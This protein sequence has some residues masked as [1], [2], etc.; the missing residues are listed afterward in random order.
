[1]I[2]PKLSDIYVSATK[3]KK[4][5]IEVYTLIQLEKSG[6]RAVFYIWNNLNDNIGNILSKL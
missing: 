5:M 6:K 4:T 3:E 1:M 2:L